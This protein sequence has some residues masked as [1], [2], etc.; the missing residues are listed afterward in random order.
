MTKTPRSLPDFSEPPIYELA[1]GIQ[2]PPIG[3]L[4]TAHIGAFWPAIKEQF[5]TI[6]EYPPLD[7]IEEAFGAG[8]GP[9]V[10]FQLTRSIPPLRCWFINADSSEVVQIQQD[11]L[12]FNWRKG[13][14]GAT[15]PRYENVRDRFFEIYNK[16]SAFLKAGDLGVIEPQQ[17]EV[18]YYNR[19]ELENGEAPFSGVP[20][21][22]APW[23]GKYSEDFL[24][25]LESGAM[26]MKYLMRSQGGD[27]FGRFHVQLQPKIELTN[28]T[29]YYGLD[30]VSR[31]KPPS[32][33]ADGVRAFFEEG[34]VWGVKGF[35]AF[36]EKNM[37]KNWKRTN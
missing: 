18:S 20:S 16:F 19:F 22:I 12:L 14:E 33:D 24:P 17:C 13:A 30:L 3:K 4:R 25:D 9:K 31:G 21:L 36:T 5:P 2:F 37:H 15:Y 28:K 29:L 11:R 32:S 27:P 23:S 34:H 10:Q 7:N 6:E 35:A 26:Y 8:S 1:L